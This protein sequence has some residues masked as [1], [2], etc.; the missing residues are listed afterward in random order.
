MS[1]SARLALRTACATS[2]RCRNSSPT[3]SRS[4]LL[5]RMNFTSGDF[6]NEEDEFDWAAG[7]VMVPMFLSF[8]RVVSA[9]SGATA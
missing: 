4:T 9:R 2:A 7:L 8:A 1:H 5:E 6:P 3:S